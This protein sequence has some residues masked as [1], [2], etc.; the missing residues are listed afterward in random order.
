MNNGPAKIKMINAS[1]RCFTFGMLALLPIIGIPFG[2]IALVY[3]GKARAG[4]K[5]FWNPAHAHVL[6]GGLVAALCTILWSFIFIL[7]IF[8][9]LNPG[10]D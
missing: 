1:M 9:L 10:P 7:I 6:A 2:I 8:N 4:Q 5:K 3:A